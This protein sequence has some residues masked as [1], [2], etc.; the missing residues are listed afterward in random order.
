M[1]LIKEVL[2][3][4]FWYWVYIAMGSFAIFFGLLMFY[5]IKKRGRVLLINSL[6]KNKNFNNEKLLN[7]YTIQSFYTVIIGIVILCLTVFSLVNNYNIF[8]GLL[9]FGLC[10]FIFDYF[11]IKKSSI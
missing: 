8:I 5:G 9:V 11:A 3:Y 10:D 2:E 6:F 1:E 7:R 4:E